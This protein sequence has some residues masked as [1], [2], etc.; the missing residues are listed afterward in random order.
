MVFELFNKKGDGS[1]LSISHT[2]RLSKSKANKVI[3]KNTQLKGRVQWKRKTSGNLEVCLLMLPVTFPPTKYFHIFLQHFRHLFWPI[4]RAVTPQLL[5]CNS[6]PLWCNQLVTV[7]RM[8]VTAQ[9]MGVTA[10]GWELQHTRWGVTAHRM[11]Q[12]K[13][14]KC[15][16][17]I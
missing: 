15:C 13:C 8:G 1:I 6:H 10:Q 4:R 11:G 16:R 9:R 14:R 7:Q 5:C 12:N 17:K 3:Y 2:C